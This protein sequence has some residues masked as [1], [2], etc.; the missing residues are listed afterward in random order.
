MYF[1]NLC[2]HWLTVSENFR[3]SQLQR[4]TLI[5]RKKTP[6]LSKVKI[7]QSLNETWTQTEETNKNKLSYIYP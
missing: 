3:G 5:V 1:E 7:F 4:H 2:S 6:A